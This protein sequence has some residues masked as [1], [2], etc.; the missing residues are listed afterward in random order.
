VL[1]VPGYSNDPLVDG[2]HLLADPMFWPAHLLQYTAGHPDDLCV[3]FGV[4]EA[5]LWLFYRRLTDERQWPV[6]AIALPLGHV[7]YVVYRNF[8]EDSGNDYLLHHPGWA[9]PILLATVE[10]HYL[11]PALCWS[12]LVAV[13]RAGAGAD[14]TLSPEGRIGL[15]LPVM[16]DAD[17]PAD[18]VDFLA[19]ALHTLG[20]YRH[21]RRLAERFL[22]EQGL[23]GPQPWRMVNGARIS[24][25][26]RNATRTSDVLT[27]DILAEIA[28][29]LAATSPTSRW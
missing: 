2:S 15:L 19:G 12:E 3:A 16:A 14:A 23:W 28:R 29:A 20:A 4:D 18:A 24:A 8:A 7:L 9:E 27:N 1:N 26:P 21:P 10:G 17:L 5:E 22:D 25:A 6:F 11:G 13:S